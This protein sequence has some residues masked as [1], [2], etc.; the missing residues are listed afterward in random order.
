MLTVCLCLGTLLSLVCGPEASAADDTPVRLPVMPARLDADAVCT[1]A[2]AQ[3]ATTVPWEQRSLQLTRTW[4]FSDGSGV[5]VAV[6]DTGVSTTA[7]ALSGRV[8]AV[9]PA[10][11]DCVGHGTFVAGLVAAATV[12]GVRFAGVAQRARI[13]AVRGT[14]ERG[15]A[16]AQSVA[17]GIAAAT[18][19]GADVITVSPALV[20]GSDGLTKAVEAALA[21]D[22]LVIAAAV[23]DPEAKSSAQGEEPTPRDYWPAAQPGVLSVL[24]VDA[25]GLRPDEALLPVS[26]DLAAPGAGVVG[27]GA[28]GTGHY[29]G[30]GASLAAAYVAGAA[31][32]VRSSHPGLTG[33][34]T[35]A[36]ITA[37][38]YPDVVPRLDPFAAVTEVTPGN[39]SGAA[40]PAPEAA[41][42]L[43]DDDAAPPVR[44]ATLFAA[45]GAALILL[46]AWAALTLPRARTRRW[47]PAGTPA[48][49]EGGAAGS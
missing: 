37:S 4:P 41:V 44:R 30:S 24:D 7:S 15:A 1:G 32:L 49:E 36:R 47:R 20:R 10:D 38:A 8:T 9:G 21:K 22:V 39:A 17:S 28:R 3:R 34:E 11:Q 48:A 27:I 25:Q 45:A 16:T 23:P 26:A 29:I 46:V 42:R 31:A 43:P 13:L 40:A 33:A 12:D 2:S 18:A 5:T 35:A 14:D 6:V 19:A